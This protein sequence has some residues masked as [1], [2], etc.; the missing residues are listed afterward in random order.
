MSLSE[1]LL[2]GFPENS[3]LAKDIA[4]RAKLSFSEVKIHSFPDGES[5]ITLPRELP[6]HV[7]IC[8][9]LDHPN[10]K[11]VE[12]LLVAE[13][14]RNQGVNK[15]TFVVPYL[16]Y[17]RQD[18]AF[19]PGEVVSQKVV[20]K[21]LSETFD[22]VLTVDSHLHRINHLSEAIPSGIAINITATLAM[23][24]FIENTFE[25]P[26]LLGPDAESFQWVEAIAQHSQMD[27]AVATKDR[28]GDTD[29]SIHLPEANFKGRNIIIVDDVASSGQ[30]LIQAAKKL[31]DLDVTE[32]PASISVLVTH[33]LF[34]PGSMEMLNDAGVKN[35]WSSNSINHSS[36]AVSLAELLAEN[37]EPFMV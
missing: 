9:S 2:L 19:N 36:N 29:V 20:G 37:L 27:F 28:K 13:G 6:N 16:S 1:T 3:E 31:N 8:R 33:A 34:M 7:I 21:L 4:E 26:F 11:L 24:K 23:S 14:C 10:E 30:T 18:I 25:Q 12:V 17:M 35:I 5:K 32:R 22:G 15:L